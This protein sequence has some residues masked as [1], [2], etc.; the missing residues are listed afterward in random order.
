MFEFSLPIYFGVMKRPG[1][2]D[3]KQMHGIP[4]RWASWCRRRSGA[5]PRSCSCPAPPPPSKA[6]SHR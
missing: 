3:K 1:R 6:R 2:N 4:C 5:A